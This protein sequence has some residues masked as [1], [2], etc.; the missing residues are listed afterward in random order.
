M[1]PRPV[2]CAHR[3]RRSKARSAIDGQAVLFKLRVDF[4]PLESSR[5]KVHQVVTFSR[6]GGQAF[7]SGCLS[8]DG[9]IDGDV[10][11]LPEMHF[12]Q[13]SAH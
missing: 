5:K 10:R 12:V 2:T 9:E 7:C 6:V 8:G 11:S 4:K 1:E 3:P 13:R